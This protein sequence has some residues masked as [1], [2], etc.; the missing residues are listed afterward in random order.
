MHVIYVEN[1]CPIEDSGNLSYNF[2]ASVLA[3][4]EF[5]FWTV[6]TVH[7]EGFYKS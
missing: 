1:N 7:L 4:Q 5:K 3:F 2:L 6:I